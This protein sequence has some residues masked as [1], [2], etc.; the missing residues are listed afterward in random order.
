MNL[1]SVTAAAESGKVDPEVKLLRGGGTGLLG[2]P[3]LPHSEAAEPPAWQSGAGSVCSLAVHS[4]AGLVTSS[5]LTGAPS[6]E[7]VDEELDF[8]GQATST[9]PELCAF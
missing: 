2:K 3:A 4:N 7:T 9:A 6:L 5:L 1:S 8:G